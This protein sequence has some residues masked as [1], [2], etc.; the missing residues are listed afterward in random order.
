MKTLAAVACGAVLGVAGFAGYLMWYF[1]D[2]MR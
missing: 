1:R 2:V